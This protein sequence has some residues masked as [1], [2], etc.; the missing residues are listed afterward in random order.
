LNSFELLRD[1]VQSFEVLGQQFILPPQ[2]D[3]ELTNKPLD[4]AQW[5][6]KSNGE[7]QF[8]GKV[9]SDL[10]SYNDLMAVV[11]AP[12]E[13]AIWGTEST[14]LYVDEIAK[15]HESYVCV[16][17]KVINLPPN[18]LHSNWLLWG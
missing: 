11:C 18:W 13:I 5:E 4:N 9:L 2:N 1:R 15:E 8:T 7:V 16:G 10:S 3:L 14:Y 6:M 17:V 12:D